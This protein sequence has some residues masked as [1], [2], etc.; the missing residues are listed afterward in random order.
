MILHGGARRLHFLELW[1]QLTRLL[2][3]FT[4][5]IAYRNA[6][7]PIHARS[8]A[9]FLC[10]RCSV[11][12]ASAALAAVHVVNVVVLLRRRLQLRPIHKGLQNAPALVADLLALAPFLGPLQLGRAQIAAAQT[13]G[14]GSS[15]RHQTQERVLL[16]LIDTAL[17]SGLCSY[18][19]ATYTK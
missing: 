7:R 2:H 12:I 13:V 5:P 1:L 17:Q 16:V 15:R 9:S 8:P 18:I 10:S 3:A 6:S 4:I 19:H 11:A 14:S